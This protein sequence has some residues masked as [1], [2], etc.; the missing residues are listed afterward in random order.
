MTAKGLF[1][2]LGS[3]M[4]LLLA[5]FAYDSFL[6]SRLD[7]T[8][9]L[10]PARLAAQGWHASWTGKVRR[11]GLTGPYLDLLR[12]IV[13]DERGRGWAAQGL[14][15]QARFFHPG[16]VSFATAGSQVLR[17]GARTTLTAGAG[18][19][20]VLTG[21]RQIV[22]RTG[23]VTLSGLPVRG[24][25]ML[26]FSGVT[27]RLLL[28][29]DGK[30]DS[31]AWA[32]DATMGSVMPKLV[33]TS[34]PNDI[35]ERLSGLLSALPSPDHAR[36]VIAG[37]RQGEGEERP[38]TGHERFLIQE[39]SFHLGPLFCVARGKISDEGTG[40]MWSHM[41]GVRA[42]I[43]LWLASIPESVVD[44]PDYARILKTL[45]EQSA[46]IPDRLDLPLPS[47]M[48]DI[49]L[50]NHFSAIINTDSR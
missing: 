15:L 1:L 49:L 21:S 13:T 11:W 41:E 46:R 27:A 37:L 12:P 44:N 45:H 20:Y 16:S 40:A 43:A 48:D 34:S 9:T 28:G 36:L 25:E 8:L 29:S 3:V 5:V 32:L 26:A 31:P 4:T 14:S 17:L 50:Q 6:L 42:F 19:G 47:V 2:T 24:V 38:E 35:V 7:E 33:V 23:L 30:N 18:H 39:A 10:L 22:L